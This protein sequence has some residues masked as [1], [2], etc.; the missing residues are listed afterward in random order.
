MKKNKN[1]KKGENMTLLTKKQI[2]DLEH[3]SCGGFLNSQYD[4]F[5]IY[6]SGEYNTNYSQ[7]KIQ[8]QKKIKIAKHFQ[9]KDCVMKFYY[10]K[11][12]PLFAFNHY[13]KKTKSLLLWDM[14]DNPEPQWC[15][16]LKNKVLAK[17]YEYFGNIKPKKKAA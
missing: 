15:V 11:L 13:K 9:D 17:K 5:E 12:E 16:L 2:E 6:E 4:R 7:P 3:S 8:K 1:K 10:N 14:A